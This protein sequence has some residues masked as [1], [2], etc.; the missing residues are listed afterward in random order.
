MELQCILNILF[1]IYNIILHNIKFI[2][3]ICTNIYSYTQTFMN[4]FRLLNSIQ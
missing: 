3:H 1:Y 4:L 2:L